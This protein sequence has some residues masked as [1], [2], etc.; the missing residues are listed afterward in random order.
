MKHYFIFETKFTS[1]TL[2]IVNINKVNSYVIIHYFKK[3][4]E[5]L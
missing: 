3:V 5:F 1:P 4:P 2:S